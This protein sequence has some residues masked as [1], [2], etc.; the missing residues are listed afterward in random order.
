M[1][2]NKAKKEAFKIERPELEEDPNGQFFDP[3]IQSERLKLARPK[4]SG[5]LFVE[6]GSW[7]R[8]AETQRLRVRR[9]G[10]SWAAGGDDTGFH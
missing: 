9:G 3:A 1:N 10:Y 6:E 8:R 5:F 7:A 4:K 2:I